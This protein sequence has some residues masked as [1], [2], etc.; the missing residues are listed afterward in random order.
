VVVD[1]FDLAVERLHGAG[2]ATLTP[3]M[4][5]DGGRRVCFREPGADAIVE[6]ME[7]TP[8]P[9]VPARHSGT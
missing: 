8:G 9:P 3:P 4:T 2:L 6:I 5:A 7:A 1:D